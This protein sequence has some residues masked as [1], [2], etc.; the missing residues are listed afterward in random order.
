M[1]CITL[2]LLWAA[3]PV[4][5]YQHSAHGSCFSINWMYRLKE[6]EKNPKNPQVWTLHKAPEVVGLGF[7]FTIIWK[8]KAADCLVCLPLS[9]HGKQPIYPIG[10]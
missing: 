7:Y 5:G 4:D 6:K 3:V 2:Y 1:K 8:F 9:Y 10:T